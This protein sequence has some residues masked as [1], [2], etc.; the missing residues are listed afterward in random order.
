[1][2]QLKPG[3]HSLVGGGRKI[4]MIGL[5]ENVLRYGSERD[6]LAYLLKL[7]LFDSSHEGGF[8]RSGVV[9]GSW[10]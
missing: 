9:G 1:M 8:A 4:G 2:K 3:D 5:N 7:A 10:R 6:N